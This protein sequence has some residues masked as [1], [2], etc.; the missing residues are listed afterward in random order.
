MRPIPNTLP[1]AQKASIT[2]DALTDALWRLVQRDPRP[3]WL[4]D[5]RLLAIATIRP[6]ARKLR[7]VFQANHRNSKG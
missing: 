2:I 5:D 4:T 1:R 3:D 6:Y 7:Q